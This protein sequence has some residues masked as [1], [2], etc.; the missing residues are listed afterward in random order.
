MPRTATKRKR[1]DY[2]DQHHTDVDGSGDDM[3]NSSCSS[4][5]SRDHKRALKVTLHHDPM[6]AA[7]LPQQM[8]LAL[9]YFRE[10]KESLV[11]FKEF[12]LEES[13]QLDPEL[14]ERA[15]SVEKTLLYLQE[16]LQLTDLE[17]DLDATQSERLTFRLLQYRLH[18]EEA[19]KTRLL[20]KSKI[21]DLERRLAAAESA[22]ENAAE[23]SQ[24]AEQLKL[25]SESQTENA[26]L[27]QL[28]RKLTA[29]NAKLRVENGALRADHSIIAAHAT[30]LQQQ[31]TAKQMENQ[32]LKERTQS[33]GRMIEKYV[34][35]TYQLANEIQTKWSALITGQQLNTSFASIGSAIATLHEFCNA[36]YDLVNKSYTER[37][38]P[39]PQLF[40]FANTAS[41]S[42]AQQAVQS[43]PNEADVTQ[44]A[45]LSATPRLG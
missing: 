13:T 42:L 26:R 25:I 45:P 16:L 8:Q 23:R 28:V 5:E 36:R 43:T 21:A 3:P 19:K 44:Q 4:S 40:A 15:A 38:L 24:P 14:N 12:E 2:E 33:V 27:Q 17:V 31:L 1:A 41:T 9:A 32:Q 11:F 30:S 7:S 35:S 10:I 39:M 29:E 18:A 6:P 22:L 37:G 34:I 20:H